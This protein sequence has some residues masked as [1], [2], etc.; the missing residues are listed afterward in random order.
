VS[1]NAGDKLTVTIGDIAFGGEGVARVDDF[2]VFVP[3]VI[4]GE[5][6]EIEINEVKQRF[7]R[8]RLYGC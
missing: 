5:T 6:V 2:V 7:G 1:P 4:L 8:A 3:F